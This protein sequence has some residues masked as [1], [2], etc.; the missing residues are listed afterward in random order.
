MSD[1]TITATTSLSPTTVP[2]MATEIKL[3]HDGV[4]TEITAASGGTFMS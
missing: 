4:A 3:Y 1:V 2:I